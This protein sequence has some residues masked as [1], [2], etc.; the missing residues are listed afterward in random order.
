MYC[1]CIYCFDTLTQASCI[2]LVCVPG[3]VSSHTQYSWVEAL[4][5]G[6]NSKNRF[7]K[8][9]ERGS[10]SIRADVA[11][12]HSLAQ[13]ESHTQVKYSLNGFTQCKFHST[14][15]LQ[16]KLFSPKLQF[17][18]AFKWPAADS[19]LKWYF[20]IHQLKLIQYVRTMKTNTSRNLEH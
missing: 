15:T 17:S 19:L 6:C 2:C 9:K 1:Q 20:Y 14:L 11:V 13:T 5:A 16:I 18:S 7:K 3:H 10:L 4:P 8:R 12:S